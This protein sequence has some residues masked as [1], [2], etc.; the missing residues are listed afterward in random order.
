MEAAGISADQA[1]KPRTSEVVAEF[2]S[3]Y[4]LIAIL[5]AHIYIGSLGME[6]AYDAMGSGEVDLAWARNH[7]RLWVEEEQARTA[8]GP[9][10]GGQ[11]PAP[12]E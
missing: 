10:T 9:Q 4:G 3:K 8:S 2:I 12:A 5:I 7:H 1:L 6:G 11:H